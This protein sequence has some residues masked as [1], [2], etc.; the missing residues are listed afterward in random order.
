MKEDS[1]VMNLPQFEKNLLI[2]MD[3]EHS[4]D[5]MVKVS[6]AVKANLLGSVQ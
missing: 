3:A 6:V 1:L 2:F 4:R 5:V